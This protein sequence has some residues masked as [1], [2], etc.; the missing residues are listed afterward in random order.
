VSLARRWASPQSATI[1]WM[2]AVAPWLVAS[3]VVLIVLVQRDHDDGSQ[4]HAKGPFAAGLVTSADDDRVQLA[5]RHRVVGDVVASIDAQDSKVGDRIEIAYDIDDPYRLMRRSD[6]PPEDLTG[7]IVASSVLVGVTTLF[8]IQWS[9]RRSRRLVADSTTTF[10]MTGSLH[11][12]RT[13]VVPRL[14]LYPLD[15][16]AGDRPVCTI[17]LAD[18]RA[19]PPDSP[20]FDLEVKGIP[21]PGGRV[22]VRHDGVVWWPRGRALIVTRHRRPA[23][24]PSPRAPGSP[25]APP[26]WPPLPSA[27]S[28]DS[29]PGGCRDVGRT[30]RWIAVCGG[31]GVVA[32]L[33]VAGIT[34]H[35]QRATERWTSDGWPALATVVDHSE[36]GV[37]VDVV[38]DA[39]AGP[40]RTMTAPVDFPED[41]DVGRKYPVII[42]ADGQ[43]VRLLAEPYDAVEPILFWAIPTAIALW[44][45]AWRALGG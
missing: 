12:S 28:I 9:A 33:V 13:S 5:Y 41:F 30:L 34:L 3:T 20:C 19:S 39:D 4:L 16:V 43:Q 23:A 35:N 27:P 18:V 11:C 24:E 7:W 22:V 42:S 40:V 38:D 6:Q 2:L 32:T 17:R 25:L 36:F 1:R 31:V 26:P 14:S 45:V 15:S 8:M 21:R 29:R 37:V 10:A 44:W